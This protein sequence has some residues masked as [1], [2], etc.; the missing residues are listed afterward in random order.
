MAVHCCP[1]Q[2]SIETVSYYR[3]PPMPSITDKAHKVAWTKCVENQRLVQTGKPSRN[4][5]NVYI[6]EDNCKLDKTSQSPDGN[7]AGSG[8]FPHMASLGYKED[9]SKK[10]AWH[11]TE[12]LI[13]A[14]H[15]LTSAHVLVHQLVSF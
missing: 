3:L 9:G 6:K 7:L 13:S 10:I 1:K 4:D 12:A 15:I 2:S 11:A 8:E 5:P 14:K